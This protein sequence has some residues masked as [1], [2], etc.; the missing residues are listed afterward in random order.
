LALLGRLNARAG[1]PEEAAQLLDDALAM[2]E[3]LRAELDAAFVKVLQAEAA[4]FAGNSEVAHERALSLL[5]R[6]PADALLEPLALVVAGA[7]LA[8]LG[9][10]EAAVA[11]LE[12]ALDAA[13]AAERP[14]ETVLALDALVRL[15]PA[16]RRRPERDALLAQLDVARLPAPPLARPRSAAAPVG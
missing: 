14:F 2:F 9:D 13:R 8:Q 15:S 6:V 12:L 10:D 1:R 7:A 11:E 16:D 4:A 5:P 3:A